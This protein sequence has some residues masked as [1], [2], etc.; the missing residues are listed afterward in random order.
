LTVP[1]FRRITHL[2]LGVDLGPEE[3]SIVAAELTPAGVVVAEALTR[4]VP[5]A[6][7]EIEP[8][9]RATLRA[10]TLAL[11]TK[12]RRCVLAAPQADV[13]TRVFRLPEGMRRSEAE[14]AAVLEADAIANWPS[15]ERVVALDPI[16]GR[17]NEMLLSIARTATIVR[18]VGV[19]QLAGLVPIA[20]DVPAC[21]WQRALSG[22]EAVLDVRSERAAL[23]I[24]GQPVGTV[25][26]LAPR[27]DDERLVAQV[28]SVL[29]Q[30]R[31]DGVADVQRLAIAGA[32]ARYAA[33][34]AL[35]RSDGYAVE[36]VC[37]AGVELPSW[38]LAFGLALWSIAPRGLRAA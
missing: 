2:P 28:R 30:A 25:E 20:V 21:A 11:K 35:L 23:V 34:E 19:A 31:R 5:R 36:P 8:A 33:L 26:L 12:E 14:R 18:R 15:T 29:I 24:F 7:T 1:L 22:G 10:L 32:P 4:A 9:V 3:V 37:L 38:A 27:L 16:P 17:A 13:T 6:A